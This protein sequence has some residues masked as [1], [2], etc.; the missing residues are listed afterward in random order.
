MS[1]EVMQLGD[2]REDLID[3]LEALPLIDREDA[4]RVTVSLENVVRSEAN[5]GARKIVIP[6]LIASASLS[7][8]AIGV[9]LRRG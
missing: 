5:A 4:T 3:A 2:F 1:V 6:A 9:A 7:I 8:L